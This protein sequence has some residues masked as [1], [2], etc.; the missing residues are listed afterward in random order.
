[1]TCTHA[2]D[3]IDAGPFIDVSPA[4]RDAVQR[5]ARECAACAR[6]MQAA[7]HLAADL[8]ALAQ[9]APPPD[10]TAAVLAAIARIEPGHEAPAS[11]RER[12]LG[13]TSLVALGSGLAILLATAITSISGSGP[14]LVGGAG[15]VPTTAAAALALTA[16]LVLYVGGL[17]GPVVGRLR[18]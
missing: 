15:A 1:M 7:E 9:P 17:F 13:V 6:A 18:R 11:A 2:L 4:H 16:G 14:H 8:R 5:H 12:T 10:L 3:F